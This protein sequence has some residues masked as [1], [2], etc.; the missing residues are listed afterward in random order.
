LTKLDCPVA[1]HKTNTATARCRRNARDKGW[2][3]ALLF[4]AVMKQ[5][6]ALA[7]VSVLL[8]SA[9]TIMAV[10]VTEANPLPWLNPRITITI[11]SPLNGTS[12]DL[13]VFVNFTAQCSWEFTLSDSSIQ[14]WIKA[15]Y[16]VLDGQDMSSSGTNFTE[17]QLTAKHPADKDYYYEYN[18]QAY[19]TNLTDGSHS[20]TVYY[21]ALINADSPNEFIA[22]KEVWS[23]TSQFYV[24]TEV[25]PELPLSSLWMI[26][27]L[28]MVATLISAI[29]VKK[30]KR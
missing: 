21:G 2:F 15:F 23:A 7:L 1:P 20:V 26:L 13:P 9:A 17:I 25:T 18:G 12:H 16:Y 4:G 5:Q 28:F 10:G 6:A 8:F 19:L 24:N 30:R 22:Y 11:Q 27:P 3:Y 14:D 29:L